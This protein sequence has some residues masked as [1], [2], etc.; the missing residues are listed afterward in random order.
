LFARNLKELGRLDPI[1]GQEAMHS[2][3]RCVAWVSGIEN[4]YPPA[5][6]AEHQCRTQSGR[7]AAHN[8]YIQ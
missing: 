2:V 5:T 4:K 6:A 7:A 1:A 8:H 3:R